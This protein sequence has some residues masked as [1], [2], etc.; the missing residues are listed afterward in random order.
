MLPHDWLTWRLGA[1]RAGH[2]PWRRLR[3]R[4]LLPGRRAAGCPRSPPPRS[5]TGR[6]LPRRGRPA[7]IGGRT[8]AGPRWS[9]GHRGQ[10]GAP[11]SGWAC[12]RATWS[13]RS[14]RPGRRSRSPRR[15]AADPTGA[16]AGFADAT[17]RFLP[18]VCTVNAGLVLA[19]AAALLGTDLDGLSAAGADRRAR[20]GRA[21]PAALPGRRAH[22]GPAARHRRAARPDHP[23]RD[24]AEPRPGRGRGGAG[25]AG[26]GGRPARRAAGRSADRVLLIGGGARS[27]AVRRLAPG[28]FGAPVPGARARGVRRARRGPPGGVGAGRHR[29]A[30]R[31]AAPAARRVHRAAA[32]SRPGA[33]G[34]AA[35]GHRPP[36]TPPAGDAALNV[37]P[38]PAPAWTPNPER[39]A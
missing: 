38:D 27:E 6:G 1:G 32:A 7:E 19:A 36:G 10:H 33:A 28:I 2:R 14:A 3:H 30:T 39:T 4:L 25:L 31:L 29:R 5:A 18:L 37:G 24:P 26:R 17:G 23:Q 8:R 11:R 20:R 35:R 16:V 34:L 21:H 9:R 13:S 22:P 15:P 12:S